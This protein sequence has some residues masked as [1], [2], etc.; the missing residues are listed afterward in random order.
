MTKKNKDKSNIYEQ[1]Y[2]QKKGLERVN[3][4]F[5]VSSYLVGLLRGME[6]IHNK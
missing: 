4:I 5:G 1:Q 6:V 3:R 2:Y